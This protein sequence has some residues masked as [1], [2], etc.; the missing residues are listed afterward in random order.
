MSLKLVE[1]Q[2]ALPKMHDIGKIQ[3]QLQH[4]PELEQMQLAVAMQ[5]QEERTKRQVTSK[6]TSQNIRWERERKGH[7]QYGE[8]PYKGNNIDLMG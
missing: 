6:R 7:P 5:K 1:L 8:H 2:I 4:H 3:G